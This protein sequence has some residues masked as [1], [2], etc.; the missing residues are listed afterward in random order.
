MEGSVSV[1]PN[2]YNTNNSATPPARSSDTEAQTHSQTEVSGSQTCNETQEGTLPLSQTKVHDK[3]STHEF[4]LDVIVIDGAGGTLGKED[5]TNEKALSLSQTNYF[6]NTWL[7]FQTPSDATTI[8]ETE[9]TSSGVATSF[10]ANSATPANQQSLNLQKHF[11]TFNNFSNQSTNT[12]QTSSQG[13]LSG[14][15]FAQ[16]SQRVRLYSCS[17]CPMRFFLEAELAKHMSSHRNRKYVCGLCGKAFVCRSQLEI[18]Q[19]V[20]TG[21]KPFKCALCNSSFSH[22]SN[23]RRHMKLQHQHA[24][25]SANFTQPE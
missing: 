3:N 10:G 9:G 17:K 2:V 22:P 12:S 7:S 18:H 6:E 1:D 13:S 15:I 5:I 21:E 25:N 23:L 20:H 16:D 11:Q 19:N 14:Q 4:D 8:N 24:L